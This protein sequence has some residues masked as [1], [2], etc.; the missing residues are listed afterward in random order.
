[1]VLRRDAAGVLAIGQPAHARLCGQLARLWGNERFG[2]VRPLDEVALGAEQHDIG[3]A[4]W[5]LAPA[6]NPATGLPTTFIEMAP[7]VNAQL[8]RDGPPTLISQSRY[9]A[10]L[11]TMHGRRL[12]QM[13]DVDS[14][15]PDAAAVVRALRDE[16]VEREAE[17]TAALRADPDVA[18]L[19]GAELIT[20]NSDLV[21][22]WDA[23][24]LAL[25]LD[26]AP[27]TFSAVPAAGRTAVDMKLD[28]VTGRGREP[29]LSLSPWPFRERD[30]VVVMTEGRRLTATYDSDAALSAGLAA[31]PWETIRFRLVPAGA[32]RGRPVPTPRSACSPANPAHGA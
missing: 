15:A 13:R 4:A 29:S 8:W 23:L 9:A 16:S 21:W 3:M 1:M 14:L 27:H 20:R 30:G 18:E 24:S 6:R 22:T 32:A 31:A 28:T 5:D 12:S 19:A 11:A 25:L 17:L 2:A 26:W 10:L 7:E